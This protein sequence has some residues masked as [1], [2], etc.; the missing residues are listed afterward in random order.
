MNEDKDLCDLLRCIKRL[1]KES[2]TINKLMSS[3][4]RVAVNEVTGL[5]Q[6]EEVMVQD[7]LDRIKPV[8]FDRLGDGAIDVGLDHFCAT[9]GL[10]Y[11]KKNNVLT[12]NYKNLQFCIETLQEQ[13]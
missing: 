10:R 9:N 6:N 2:K 13:R 3:R 5:P 4:P 12:L 7:I 1:V 11:K 8:I